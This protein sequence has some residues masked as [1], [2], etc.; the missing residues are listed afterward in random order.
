MLFR[1]KQDEVNCILITCYTELLL[2]TLKLIESIKCIPNLLINTHAAL[3]ARRNYDKALSP[4][5]IIL[6]VNVY[7]HVLLDTTMTD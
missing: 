5:V 3:Y 4:E 6:S 1:S 2:I 7:Q